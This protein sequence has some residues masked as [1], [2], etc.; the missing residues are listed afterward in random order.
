M[1]K[2]PSTVK[3]APIALVVC[4]SVY[5]DEGSGKAALVGLFNNITVRDLPTVHPR[6]AVFASVTG[7]RE[8]SHA[9]LEIVEAETGNAIASAA[10]PFPPGATPL[11]VADL[12]FVIANV[13]F[14]NEGLYNVQ[15]WVNDYLLMCR[16]FR[17]KVLAQGKPR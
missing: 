2:T 12:T 3:P 4:D 14:E 1:S 15:F 6:L 9:K 17:V 10:G 16:P 13:K 7:L 5:R 8:S 11:M